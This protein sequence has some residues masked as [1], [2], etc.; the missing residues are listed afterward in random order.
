MTQ[1]AKYY[2]GALY[3]LARDEGLDEK[4][5]SQMQTLAEAFAQS[6][7]YIRLLAAPSIPKKQR[8]G[9]LEHDFSKLL[10]PY[11][12][13]F[14]MLLTERG[15]IREYADCCKEFRSRYNAD[16][17]ILEVTAI[18]AVPLPP[19]LAK[20]L[21][22]KLTAISGKTIALSNRVDRRILGGVRLEMDGTQLD[23]TVRHKLDGIRETLAN[24]V[25]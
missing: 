22:Q 25:L 7:D 19:A 20:K 24:T 8:C 16:H 13:H 6:P 3:E 14:L 5:L 11:L 15:Y 17:Q 23:G 21:T 1:T 9:V 18:T 10:H 12:L 2:G 4:I